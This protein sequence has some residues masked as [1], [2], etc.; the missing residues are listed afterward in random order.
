MQATQIMLIKRDTCN[1]LSSGRLQ[2]KAHVEEGQVN[3][4]RS[5]GDQKS[6]PALSPIMY[7]SSGWEEEVA[8]ANYKVIASFQ[9]NKEATELL[10]GDSRGP[11]SETATSPLPM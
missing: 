7:S 11:Q 4:R 1:L 2:T 10:W 5:P 8:P 9:G 6:S 3:P